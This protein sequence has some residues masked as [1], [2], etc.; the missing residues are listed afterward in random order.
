MTTFRNSIVGS[1]DFDDEKTLHPPMT[2][3]DIEPVI[4]NTPDHKRSAVAFSEGT[5]TNFQDT[6]DGP[7]LKHIYAAEGNETTGPAGLWPKKGFKADNIRYNADGTKMYI[8]DMEDGSVW[9]YG[10]TSPYNCDWTTAVCEGPVSEE[11]ATAFREGKY[12]NELQA[13]I[14]TRVP[15]AD[16]RVRPMPSQME[17]KKESEDK[18]TSVLVR[19]KLELRRR[20][21]VLKCAMKKLWQGVE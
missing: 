3:N 21:H 12:I 4:D 10:L 14:Q 9:Q 6:R 7:V 20:S 11:K 13:H 15:V 8:Q 1:G 18:G 19:E 2:I 17:Y 5:K 16:E